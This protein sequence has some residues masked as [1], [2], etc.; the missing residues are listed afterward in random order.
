MPAALALPPGSHSAARPPR[1]SAHSPQVGTKESDTWSPGSKPCASGP[2]STT[3]PAASW[4]STIGITRGREP[5]ITDRSEW[6][7]PAARTLTSI[8]PGPGGAS[9]SSATS[10]G[11]DCA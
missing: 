6:H 4:P 9:S 8:S 5:S 10:S 1:H 3:S 11:R 7:S 2:S